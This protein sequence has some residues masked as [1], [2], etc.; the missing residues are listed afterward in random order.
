[1]SQLAD[2]SPSSGF[3]GTGEEVRHLIL[4]TNKGDGS[5]TKTLTLTPIQDPISLPRLLLALI[6]A[7]MSSY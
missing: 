4:P 2:S 7:S 3:S 5:K 1:M 6:K